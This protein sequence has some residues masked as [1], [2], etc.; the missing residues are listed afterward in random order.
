MAVAIFDQRID[1]IT[2][3]AMPFVFKYEFVVRAYFVD[4]NTLCNI[5]DFKLYVVITKSIYQMI[6]LNSMRKSCLL[7]CWSLFL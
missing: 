4:V 5:K 3:N 6:R 7:N 1:R 2:I